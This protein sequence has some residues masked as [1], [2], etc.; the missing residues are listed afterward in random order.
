L[1][2]DVAKYPVAFPPRVGVLATIPLVLAI[3]GGLV[4]WDNTHR[5]PDFVVAWGW[6]ILGGCVFGLSYLLSAWFCVV[7]FRARLSWMW[8]WP[9]LFLFFVPFA[10]IVFWALYRQR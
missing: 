4:D 3:A 7:G 8:I 10:N 1:T 2:V 9:V 6:T 5:W